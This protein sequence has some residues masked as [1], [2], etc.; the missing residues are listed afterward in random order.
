MTRLAILKSVSFGGRQSFAENDSEKIRASIKDQ[1]EYKTFNNTLEMYFKLQEVYGGRVALDIMNLHY[2]KTFLIQAFTVE[3]VGDNED[4][5]KTI[6]V[7]KRFIEDNDT[8]T[9][10]EFNPQDMSSDK[11]KFSDV[12]EE[13]IVNILRR[14]SVIKSVLVSSN[15]SITNDEIIFSNRTNDVGKILIK[16]TNKEIMYLNI[17]N[18]VNANQKLSPDELDLLIKEKINAYSAEYFYIQINFQFCILNCVFKSFGNNKNET[19]TKIINEDVYDDAIIFIESNANDG[20][21]TILELDDI[22]FKRIND[23]LTSGVKKRLLNIHFFNIYRELS[24]K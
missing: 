14:R 6:V 22:L 24:T 18:I 1:V 15:G 13:D 9:F 12:M 23:L 19:L 2:D 20:N 10:G 7:V 16:T 8:Y 4:A 17:S 11:Y 21:D 3:D 5:H